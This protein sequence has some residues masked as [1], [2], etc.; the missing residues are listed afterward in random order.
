MPISYYNFPLE[1]KQILTNRDSSKISLQQ[2]IR[3]FIRLISVT[4]FGECS[5]DLDF[6]S[7]IWNIDFDKHADAKE[8]RESLTQSLLHSINKQETRLS[9]VNIRAVIEQ[10]EYK[11][12]VKGTSIRKSIRL[13]ITG[14]ITQTNEDFVCVEQ[15][16]IAPL[17]F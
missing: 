1:T 3:N 9:K 2:S 16:Y 4:H 6:G 13:T 14:I 11:G 5:F 8:L 17:S 10:T 12:H 15:F 7:P